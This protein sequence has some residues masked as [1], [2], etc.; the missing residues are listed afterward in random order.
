MGSIRVWV[1]ETTPALRLDYVR[2]FKKGT[3]EASNGKGIHHVYAYPSK[4]TS[5]K[6]TPGRYLQYV[7]H[8]DM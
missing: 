2:L 1:C 7:H 3:E 4:L 8:V 6:C 5:P